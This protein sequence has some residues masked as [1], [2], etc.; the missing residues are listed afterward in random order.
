[1]KKYWKT[2]IGRCIYQ[3]PNGIYIYQNL[4]YRWLTF[5]KISIQT[6]I[7]RYKP[8]NTT[9]PYIKPFTFALRST[10]SNCCLLGLGGGA[11]AHAT[12]SYKHLIKLTAIESNADIIHIANRYFMLN[13]IKNLNIIHKDAFLFMQT[14]QSMYQHILVDI[15]DAKSFPTNCNN[16]DFFKFCKLRLLP[17]GVLT[18]N[19]SSVSEA[20]DILKY[21]REN[22]NQRTI[23]IPVKGTANMI[24]L[25][26]NSSSVKTLLYLFEKNN[27]NQKIIWD[28]NWGYMTTM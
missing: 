27:A 10:P 16:S 14:C 19:L 22:F 20:W 7:N 26:C 1:M 11:V 5:D 4:F 6:M 17:N 25:A 15:H 24:L 2:I 21:L 9:L 8:Q 28:K 18:I 12:K 3:S 13:K 23:C